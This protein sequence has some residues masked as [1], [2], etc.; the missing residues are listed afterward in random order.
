MPSIYT[1]KIDE[2]F[3]MTNNEREKEKKELCFAKLL[4]GTLD[5]RWIGVYRAF[6][7]SLIIF[8]SNILESG[9]RGW[10]LEKLLFGRYPG[11]KEL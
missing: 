7:F 1:R 2:I 10:R 6:F 4:H 3:T 9:V 5:R 8:Y 11:R